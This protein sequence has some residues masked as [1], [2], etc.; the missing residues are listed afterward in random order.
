MIIPMPVDEN[1]IPAVIL[2]LKTSCNTLKHQPKCL[3]KEHASTLIPQSI[4][5]A[6]R[7]GGFGCVARV[8]TMSGK[9]EYGGGK[10]E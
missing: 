7:R 6:V 8:M 5:G 1:T 9:L 3:K 4:I 2:T 10:K